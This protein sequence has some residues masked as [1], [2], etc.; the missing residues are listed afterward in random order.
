MK[1]IIPLIATIFAIILAFGFGI[2]LLKFFKTWLRANLAGAKVTWASLIG[3]WLRKVPFSHIVD[4]RVTAVKAGIPFTTDQL[5][6]HFLSGGDVGHVVLAMIAAD[7]EA[8]PDSETTQKF[9]TPS[10][11]G[12]WMT[13]PY[14]HDGSAQTLEEVLEKTNGTMGTV[15]FLTKKQTRNL[16][17]YL[18]T[19]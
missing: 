3:M 13:P 6:A 5:E 7:F 10:L 2:V 8:E 14:L 18:K 16:I 4:S 15:S 19:L 1:D 17:A 12:L 11:R 9:N